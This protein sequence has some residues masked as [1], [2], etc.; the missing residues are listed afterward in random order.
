MVVP[1]HDSAETDLPTYGETFNPARLKRP[2]S[3][4]QG[5]FGGE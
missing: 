3:F 5:C 1:V 2:T 4:P